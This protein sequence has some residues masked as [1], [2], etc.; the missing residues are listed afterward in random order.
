MTDLEP[1]TQDAH[2]SLVD[3]LRNFAPNHPAARIWG[4]KEGHDDEVGAPDN[5]WAGD[6]DDVA[7]AV[8]KRLRKLGWRP[9]P[10]GDVI[11]DV[12]RILHGTHPDGNIDPDAC[13]L[14]AD[15]ME[16][17]QE[18]ANAGYLHTPGESTSQRDEPAE[19]RIIGTWLAEKVDG[20]TC[21]PGPMG[22]H[23]PGCGWEPVV[24]LT[25]VPGWESVSIP[26]PPPDEMTK[27][28][29]KALFEIRDDPYN[30][31]EWE[32]LTSVDRELY[33]CQA[34][35]ALRATGEGQHGE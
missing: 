13:K 21:G 7:E 16:R 31:D 15:S 24:D 22:E 32:D 33:E 27:R 12:A 3:L 20:C 2:E 18:I 17:A 35:A 4:R 5:V 14:C 11:E 25:T 34:R 29:A 19:Q 9:P 1:G 23:E 8:I 28:V 10:S 26:V 6:P 30:D